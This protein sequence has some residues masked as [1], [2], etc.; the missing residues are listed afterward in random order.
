MDAPQL[1]YQDP[2]QVITEIKALY[3]SFL[4]KEILPAQPEM[5]IVLALANREVN[6]NAQSDYAL[7]QVLV[8][9]AVSPMLDYLGATAGI[10]RL[11]ATPAETTIRFTLVPNHGGI[12]IPNG[13]RVSTTDGKIMFATS[14][15]TPVSAGTNSIDVHAIAVSEGKSGNDYIVG[16]VSV[17]VDPQPFLQSASNVTVTSAG[18]EIETD[19]GLRERIK[20]G[21]SRNST[22]GPISAYK[23]HTRAANPSIIDVAVTSP[24]AG[25]V[26]VY[27]LIR[28]GVATPQSVLDAVSAALNDEEVRPLNDK[29][30]V[31][32]PVRL[33]YSLTV[34]IVLRSGAI[35][36]S[37]VK[38][39]TDALIAFC[40]AK[41]N[42]LGED[43]TVS[44]LTAA[45]MNENV[46]SINFGGFSD[47]IVNP[48][49]FPVCTGIFTGTITYE[50][51]NA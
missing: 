3:E 31:A 22:A 12:I 48:I 20:L 16:T 27:P 37:T 45:A 9:F 30:V 46:H 26:N 49:S 43:I 2:S 21:P 36:S 35:Q 18:A 33:P 7:S 5:Q 4:G 47:L 28:G 24:F 1:F 17:I 15:E 23:F 38:R 25:Q 29:V 11:A 51:L 50:N 34:N 39:V 13:T 14:M 19:T 6:K 42:K 32:S 41:A 40:S 44:Q 8:D 10:F